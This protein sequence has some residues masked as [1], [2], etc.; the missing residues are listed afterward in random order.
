MVNMIMCLDSCNGLGRDN[1]LLYR[2]PSDMKMF[3]QRTLGMI[4]IMGRKTF[5]SLPKVLPHREHWVITNQ[6]EYG[7]TVPDGVKVFHS[8]EEV[9]QELGDR[10]AFVIGGSSIYQMFLDDCTNMYVTRVND[11][12]K[13]DTHFDFDESKFSHS[14]IGMGLKEKDDISGKWVNYVFEMYTRKKLK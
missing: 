10:R 4:V 14:Q 11:T 1:D 8:K 6:K 7:D 3:R 5:E 9:L 2:L 13:A 12:K